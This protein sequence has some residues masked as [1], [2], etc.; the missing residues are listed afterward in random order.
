MIRPLSVMELVND[1]LRKLLQNPEQRI[2]QFLYKYGNYYINSD[3]LLS[4]FVT[5]CLWIY[6]KLF[7]SIEEGSALS[8][9]LST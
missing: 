4:R 1:A 3:F 5:D 9:L 2:G 6:G 7:K 8:C